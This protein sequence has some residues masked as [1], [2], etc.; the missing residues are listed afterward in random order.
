MILTGPKI[1]EEVR[2][3]IERNGKERSYPVPN[4]PDARGRTK[5]VLRSRT[6]TEKRMD[7]IH[8][9]P[10]DPELVGP[11]SVDLRLGDKMLV[12]APGAIEH[13]RAERERL[14]KGV[15]HN[16]SLPAPEPPP[17]DMRA[18]NQTVPMSIPE[19]GLVLH[20]GVLYLGT[21]VECIGSD[22]Y[23]PIVEGR[24]S[25]GRLGIHVHV[26]AGFCDIGFL[27]QITL[28]IHVIHPIRVYAG[29]PICQAYFLTPD[30][31]I[32]LYKGRYRDQVGP[33]ASRIQLSKKDFP[34][35]ASN[36]K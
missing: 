7:Y 4:E 22:S 5:P 21:T 19:E 14:V 8:V 26:T 11:N 34:D 31:E 36:G 10:F 30:G 13:L 2:L 32:E 1:R 24:S 23:V 18:D 16:T 29:T 27:G 28:E 3:G 20:P 12:Y 25:V 6:V 33:V 35:G 15:V 17:L 9:E